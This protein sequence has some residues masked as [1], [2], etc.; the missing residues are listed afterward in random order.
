MLVAAAKAG[1]SHHGGHV[2][3]GVLCHNLLA[4]EVVVDGRFFCGSFP[5]VE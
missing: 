2:S 4:A 1:E 5:C 3:I